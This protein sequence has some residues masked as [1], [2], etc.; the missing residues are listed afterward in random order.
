MRRRDPD[1]E[2]NR[3]DDFRCHGCEEP[4]PVGYRSKFCWR[5][6]EE[7]TLADPRER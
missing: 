3:A 6:R 1:A 4:L 7:D 2:D 5:C